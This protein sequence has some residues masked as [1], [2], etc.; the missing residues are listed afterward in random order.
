MMDATPSLETDQRS[1]NTYA[2][3]IEYSGDRNR[4]HHSD[5]AGWGM[6]A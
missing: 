3:H 2:E 4:C 5:Q 1:E 6:V